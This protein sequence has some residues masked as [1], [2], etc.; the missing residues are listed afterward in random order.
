MAAAWSACLATETAPGADRDK[1]WF[2]L[3]F[4]ALCTVLLLAGQLKAEHFVALASAD[5]WAYMLGT[6]GAV[7]A[8]GWTMAKKA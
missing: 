4:L 5:L 1:L 6:V 7:L 3:T 8:T 2:A